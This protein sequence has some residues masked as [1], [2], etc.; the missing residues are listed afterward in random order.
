[1]YKDILRTMD[2]EAIRAAFTLA[3]F[4]VFFLLVVLEAW[5][6]SNKEIK[7]MEDLPLDDSL[8]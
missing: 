7:H 6:K 8:S 3:V 1:M 5:R 4:F 2:A